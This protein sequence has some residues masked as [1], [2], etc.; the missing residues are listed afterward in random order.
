MRYKWQSAEV[1]RQATE[2]GHLEVL[3]WARANGC[4]WNSFTCAYVADG[5]HLEVQQWARAN[6][7]KWNSFTRVFA[8]QGGHL[9]VL[10]WARAMAALS[11][12]ASIKL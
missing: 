5:G 6:G 9:K 7:C 4:Q 12:L 11:S 3:K 2:G 1:L 10:Q 8:A